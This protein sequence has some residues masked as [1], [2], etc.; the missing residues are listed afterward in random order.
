MKSLAGAQ[1]PARRLTLA[2]DRWR[3]PPTWPRLRLIGGARRLSRPGSGPALPGWWIREA[4][5]IHRHE[6]VDWHRTTDWLGRPSVDHGGMQINLGTWDE[7]APRD[8]PREPAAATPH[9]QLEVAHRIWLSN[10]DRFGGN[11]WSISA[12]DCGVP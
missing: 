5:C 8:Y 9:E 7:M 11:Q 4:M 6:S 1:R 12:A 10:G 2:P 3:E